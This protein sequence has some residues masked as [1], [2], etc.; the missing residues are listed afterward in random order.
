MKV[1]YVSSSSIPS[2]RANTIHV[3]NQVFAFKELGFDVI[4]FIR[5]TK[6]KEKDVFENV[7][8]NYNND[9]N[10]IKVFSFFS[11][12]SYGEELLIALKSV[13]YILKVNSQKNIIICRNIYASFILGFVLRKKVIY[14]THTLER[15]LRGLMQ[16]ILLNHNLVETVVITNYLKK[17]LKNHH[18][19]KI[20]N[21]SIL[22]DAARS[23]LEKYTKRKKIKYLNKFLK[24]NYKKYDLICGY[25]GHLY[26][27]RGIDVIFELAEK[28]PNIM[29]L[30]YGGT[31]DDIKKTKNFYQNE[32]LFFKG[33][34]K[35]SDSLIMMRCMD[36]LLMPY[37][38]IVSLGLK[39]FNT[40]KWMS[41]LK[42]FEYMSAG[43]PILASDLPVLKEVLENKVNCLL[44]PP[45][46]Y[47]K[48]NKA[49]KFI[50]KNKS[51][52]KYISKNSYDD[53]LEKYNWEIRAKNFL[54]IYKN[55]F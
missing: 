53:Y 2:R 11:K 12:F 29:F 9:L 27:G 23:G 47:K 32:N 16:K 42:M 5:F 48:W 33:F 39:D 25:F 54:D 51:I 38:E 21:I 30:I 36:V 41:P 19:I 35:H 20:K 6:R 34:I 18:K 44:V 49:L 15:G 40:A 4:L 14:E 13:I 17:Y 24:E 46:N 10:Q 45:N 8:L 31:E 22:P 37:K 1:I 3:I 50:K 55:R 28:N 52:S 43:V 7:K 26:S